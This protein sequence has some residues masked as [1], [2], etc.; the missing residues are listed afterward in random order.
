MNPLSESE[1]AAIWQVL[2]DHAGAWSTS[3][4][5]FIYVQ[6]DE[7]CTE[8]PFMGS[9]G[10]GGKFHRGRTWLGP[11]CVESWYVDCYP[12]DETPARLAVIDACNE[13]LAELRK[14]RAS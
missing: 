2:V 13:A 8:Y 4:E 3:R 6:T 12:E 5:N 14:E 10:M 1:A 9:L 7:P 11:D